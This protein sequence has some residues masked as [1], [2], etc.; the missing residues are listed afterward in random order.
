MRDTNGLAIFNHIDGIRVS[1]TPELVELAGVTVATLPWVHPGRLIAAHGRDVS[2]DETNSVVAELLLEAARG[3]R[4]QINGDAPAILLLHWSISG[5]SL[6]TG[7]P[8][9]QLREPVIPHDELLAL[10][11]DAIIAGHIHLRQTI[12]HPLDQVRPAFYVGS[13]LPL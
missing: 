8:V 1:S 9:D 2:R 7:L 6:P 10:G 13:P 11:F 4:A 5:S 3:L 12:G